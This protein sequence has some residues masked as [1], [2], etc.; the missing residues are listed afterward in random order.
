MTRKDEL[1]SIRKDEYKEAIVSW[2]HLQNVR[3][4][5]IGA[6]ITGFVGLI[7]A[8]QLAFPREVP[9]IEF[10]TLSANNPRIYIVSIIPIAGVVLGV[11]G[12]LS[13]VE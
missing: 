2:R 1:T 5:I 4:A 6:S 12:L 3:Y 7:G 13:L 8:F 9:S 11:A 10:G